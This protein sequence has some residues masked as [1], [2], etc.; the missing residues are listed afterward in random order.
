VLRTK[1]AEHLSGIFKWLQAIT[2]KTRGPGIAFILLPLLEG[3]Y[4]TVVHSDNIETQ[5]CD[6]NYKHF[7]QA[8]HLGHY[9]AALHAP[10]PTEENEMNLW[11]HT[12]TQKHGNKILP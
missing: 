3:K 4:E 5:I 7:G 9:K 12:L 2:E 10:P 1:R 11:T 6:S 8:Y